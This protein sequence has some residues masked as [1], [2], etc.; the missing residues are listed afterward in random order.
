[1]VTT[2]FKAFF[3]KSNCLSKVWVSRAKQSRGRHL[4]TQHPCYIKLLHVTQRHKN[5]LNGVWGPAVTSNSNPSTTIPYARQRC[6][7]VR[8]SYLRDQIVKVKGDGLLLFVVVM[9]TEKDH[10]NLQLPIFVPL[11]LIPA[12]K[13][14]TYYYNRTN[15]TASLF[16]NSF[17]LTV[18][19]W[20]W[21]C[22]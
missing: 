14:L 8:F 16:T 18:I 10:E 22:S 12:T 9:A 17:Q 11:T 2:Q 1:M 21:W 15:N 19:E 4:P 20:W 7:K 5:R 13:L 3:N 6:Y